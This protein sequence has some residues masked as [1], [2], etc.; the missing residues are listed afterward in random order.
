MAYDLSNIRYRVATPAEIAQFKNAAGSDVAPKIPSTLSSGESITVTPLS[1]DLMRAM[2]GPEVANQIAQLHGPSNDFTAR[3]NM[4]PFMKYLTVLTDAMPSVNIDARHTNFQNAILNNTQLKR[5]L[6]RFGMIGASILCEICDPIG[7]P[8][9]KK[10]AQ[11]VRN[12]LAL[13]QLYHD[14]RSKLCIEGGSNRDDLLTTFKFIDIK[15]ASRPM[16]KPFI[17]DN[18]NSPDMCITT[19]NSFNA[20]AQEL[21]T[22]QDV[23]RTGELVAI[24]PAD[25][26][27]LHGMTLYAK[28]RYFY[29]PDI[30]MVS[31][32]TKTEFVLSAPGKYWYW[33]Q[34]F[35]IRKKLDDSPENIEGYIYLYAHKQER[36]NIHDLHV[37]QQYLCASYVSKTGFAGVMGISAD[38]PLNQFA[39]QEGDSIASAIFKAMRFRL[40]EPR[41]TTLWYFP[42]PPSATEW[43][44]RRTSNVRFFKRV[45][46]FCTPED[47]HVIPEYDN[48]RHSIEQCFKSAKSR[49]FAFVG[50]PGTGKTIMMRQLTWEFPDVPVLMYSVRSLMVK[51]TNATFEFDDIIT[52]LNGAGYTSVFICCD[53]IDSV[54][55]D[56]KNE[57]VERII[58]LIDGLRIRA[59]EKGISLIFMTTINDPT[60]IHSTIIKRSGRL[61][62]VIEVPPPSAEFISKII[63]RIKAD[64]DPTDYA[65]P[66]FNDAIGKMNASRFSF[67]DIT[68]AVSNIA[69]HF[70]PDEDGTFSPNDLDASIERILASRKNAE[71]KFD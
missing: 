16:P 55:L 14:I 1:Q 36:E 12:I 42:L 32:E 56:N 26:C 15:D 3:S 28:S 18:I 31:G 11:F 19:L 63:N 34:A 67:A 25:G 59:N 29:A 33:L 8:R 60:L 44:F 37:G 35:E 70:T 50:Y 30:T 40:F 39:A 7:C 27:I 13:N 48:I 66:K 22:L 43:G 64:N 69:L 20:G 62:E 68:E 23:H 17:P 10:L 49:G 21:Y 51:E 5:D 47:F 45:N 24:K 65:D 71:K 57:Q 4:P 54:Q 38:S 58:D 41:K 46:N 2:A 6:L 9:L 52:S 61:D 53:D